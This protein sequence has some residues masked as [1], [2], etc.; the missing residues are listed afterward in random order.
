LS[1]KDSG[2]GS[3]EP[4]AWALHDQLSAEDFPAFEHPSYELLRED[5]FI[6]Q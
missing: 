1:E 2:V 6:Q 4:L 3:K 5:G